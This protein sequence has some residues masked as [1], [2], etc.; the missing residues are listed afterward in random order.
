[1]FSSKGGKKKQQKK[2]F[3]YVFE[4]MKRKGEPESPR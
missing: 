1:M 2:P 4:N 3:K